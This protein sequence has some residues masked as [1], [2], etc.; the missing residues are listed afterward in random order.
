ML[1]DGS[2]VPAHL[3][4]DTSGRSS[5]TAQ[6]LRRHE[7]EGPEM[8]TVDPHVA[9]ASRMVKMPADW[10]E[11]R[12]KKKVWF[13]FVPTR[14]A[15]FAGGGQSSAAPPPGLRRPQKQPAF[16]RFWCL[17]CINPIIS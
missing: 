13:E 8:V 9:S 1:D 16:R 17:R 4:V 6:W 3:V 5:Q 2:K 14:V 12:Q 7:L 15:A 10:D 11:V